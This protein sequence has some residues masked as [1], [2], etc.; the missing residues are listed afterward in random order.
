[1]ERLEIPMI[2]QSVRAVADPDLCRQQVRKLLKIL[3]DPGAPRGPQ[4]DDVTLVKRLLGLGAY[5]PK[6]EQ[7]ALLVDLEEARARKRNL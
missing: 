2:D 6:D 3:R 7:H 4:E 1:M 5:L